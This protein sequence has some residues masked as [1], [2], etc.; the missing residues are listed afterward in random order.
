ME[1]EAGHESPRALGE[2][3]FP[4]AASVT[5]IASIMEREREPPTACDSKNGP[6]VGPSEPLPAS[7]GGEAG[8]EE[9]EGQG[10]ELLDIALPPMGEGGSPFE[11]P[12]GKEAGTDALDDETGESAGTPLLDDVDVEA[13]EMD[14]R[15]KEDDTTPLEDEREMGEDEDVVALHSPE[16]ERFE[17]DGDSKPDKLTPGET[18]EAEQVISRESERS[19]GLSPVSNS[20]LPLQSPPTSRRN[21]RSKD[22]R[23]RDVSPPKLLEDDEDGFS[24][25]SEES[26][27]MVPHSPDVLVV[28]GKDDLEDGEIGIK[29][30]G[31]KNKSERLEKRKVKGSRKGDRERD[32]KSGSGRKRKRSRDRS[33]SMDSDRD[34]ARKRVN[35]KDLPRYDV[36]N[37]IN[38]K[39]GIKG[40]SRSRSW[41]RSRSRSR[42][43]RSR[44]RS[45]FSMSPSRSRSRSYS[46]VSKKKGSRS[47]K[48]KG[49]KP[50][51][52]S[53][54]PVR[55][56]SS[57][58]QKKKEKEK[59]LKKN[60]D[61]I[62]KKKNTLGATT[63][64]K[65]KK[66]KTGTGKTTKKKKSLPE[67]SLASGSSQAAILPTTDKEVFASGDNILVSIN[68]GQKDGTSKKKKRSADKNDIC[69]PEGNGG[70]SLQSTSNNKPSIVIDIMQSPYQVFEP[71]PQET[72]D[73]HE[74]DEE[75]SAQKPK[76]VVEDTNG[77]SSSSNN[78]PNSNDSN[79][80]N[81][82]AA[83]NGGGEPSSKGS[84]SVLTAA[85]IIESLTSSVTTGTFANSSAATNSISV[86]RGPCTPPFDEA[87]D[88]AKGPQTPPQS[89]IE[90][91]Y[92]PCNPTESPEYAHSPGDENDHE[93][94]DP[95]DLL[96]AAHDILNGN[97][98]NATNASA[99]SNSGKPRNPLKDAIIPF[100]AEASGSSGKSKESADVSLDYPID[101]DMDSPSSPQ[102]SDLSD[103]FEPPSLNGGSSNSLGK[104]KN[105]PKSNGFSRLTKTS[106]RQKKKTN[107]ATVQM[108]LVDDKLRIIDDVPTSAVEMAVK[109]KF[110]KKVQRQE[111]IVD[112]IKM[113]L[114]PFYNKKK[115]SKSSY[116]EIMRKCVPKIC[117]SKNG[118][119]NTIKIQK[120]VQGYVKKYHHFEKKQK[121][122][123]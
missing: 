12:E 79:P 116:K 48:K 101:M 76:K 30:G 90:D 55:K 122:P 3:P 66:D 84:T 67:T 118:A 61:K 41:S 108:K 15:R 38:R 91:S 120:L 105:K 24:S 114:K 46:P 98:T 13:T 78:M 97:S 69:D 121:M 64:T 51:K 49:G 89:D 95:S 26:V 81:Y 107:K 14:A 25:F 86:T 119:I 63:S 100:L 70:N 117:H 74:S 52:P 16:Q 65:K 40:R 85:S 19:G 68:F 34:R 37:I 87:I 62:G 33:R 58:S 6:N 29:K 56:K 54:S 31:K 112:E 71:S 96:L 7:D 20:S 83:T 110:L 72:I 23:K 17:L 43:V 47:T 99:N 106:S 28:G 44:S 9:V 45:P 82:Q 75:S 22:T 93:G 80:H 1:R 4:E 59:R 35:Q 77:M 18:G 113:V 115:I 5:S 21:N 73:L 123:K 10:E 57:K 50:R 8:G 39:R 102:G 60:A 53:P 92:D 36:R 94:D 2:I 111:R 103:L 32:R 88:F 109:E 42:N 11:N 27:L 104:K